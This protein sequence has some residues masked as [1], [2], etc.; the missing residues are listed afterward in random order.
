MLD[1]EVSCNQLFAKNAEVN[2]RFIEFSTEKNFQFNFIFIIFIKWKLQYSYYEIL[3]GVLISRLHFDCIVS[4]VFGGSFVDVQTIRS[5]YEEIISLR[6]RRKMFYWCRIEK[7]WSNF[8]GNNKSL[9]LPFSIVHILILAIAI[10]ASSEEQECFTA[11]E[12]AKT[13]LVLVRDS[14]ARTFLQNL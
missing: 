6:L 13:V 1:T 9:M 3:T 10:R 5:D 11:R 4:L 7:D 8:E 12:F 2:F 14:K